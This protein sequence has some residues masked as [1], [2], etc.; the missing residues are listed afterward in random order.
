[1][2]HKNQKYSFL[3]IIWRWMK[4]SLVEE[5]TEEVRQFRTV[6]RVQYLERC[7]AEDC[8]VEKNRK[9]LEKQWP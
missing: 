6:R 2:T 7:L 8:L 5:S 4:S 1:M 3:H 9:Q